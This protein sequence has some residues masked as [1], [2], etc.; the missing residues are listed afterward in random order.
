ME[1][2]SFYILYHLPTNHGEVFLYDETKNISEN[3]WRTRWHSQL[4]I[5]DVCFLPAVDC[6]A[7]GVN[8]K[9]SKITLDNIGCGVFFG[10]PFGDGGIMRYH[11]RTFVYSNLT[12]QKQVRKTFGDGVMSVTVNNFTVWSF[13][14]S[15]DVIELHGNG[16]KH[17]GST[18]RFITCNLLTVIATFLETRSRQF[19]FVQNQKETTHLL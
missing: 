13:K 3:F 15:E 2:F 8:E 10:R 19:N 6:S 7:F 16:E 9:A 12:T 5:F 17:L 18:G 1:T 14:I 4:D 11:C